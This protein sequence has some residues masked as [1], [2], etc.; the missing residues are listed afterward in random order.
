MTAEDT[1]AKGVDV[2]ARHVPAPSSISPQARAFLDRA[3]SFSPPDIDATDT[4]AVRGYIAAME[5]Q[6]RMIAGERAKPYPAAIA[7]HK[8]THVTLY[9]VTPA[10]STADDQ[11]AVLFDIHGGA[12]IVAGG[13]TA[14]Y[15]VQP[16]AGTARLKAFTV[17]YRMPPDY[18]FPAGLDDAVEAYR[19]VLERY[20]PAKIAFH[21][22]SA[23]ANLAAATILKAR[24]MGLPLPAACVLHTPGVDLSHSGDTFVTND[25]IDV[26]L[27]RGSIDGPALYAAGHDRTDPYLSPVFGDFAKGFPPTIL[28]SGTRDLLL[29]STV[30]MHRALRR[31][32]VPAE[33]HVFEAMP[34][35][36]FGGGTPEDLELLAEAA[37]FVRRQLGL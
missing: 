32:S 2:P 21:G 36:G 19:R 28:L 37:A 22:A 8:L 4:S 9:E 23:G 33:L 15:A 31:A 27:R 26:V 17:D 18:P 12:F 6:I 14:A 34:H 1:Q 7:E 3:A 20:K 29:S 16:M 24:D 13:I 11:D 25:I 30:M 10:S 35:G 5:G